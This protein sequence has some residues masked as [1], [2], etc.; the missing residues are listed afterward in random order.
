MITTKTSKL[1]MKALDERI[2]SLE[3]RVAALETSQAKPEKQ[4]SAKAK[5]S[6]KTSKPAK[7]T[8]AKSKSNDFDRKLYIKTAKQLGVKL[9]KSKSGTLK[10]A[11][12]EDRIKVYE[13]MGLE[14][15]E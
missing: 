6:A 11:R 10:V 5:K 8:S 7:K 3:K 1:T 9:T 13:A 4:V 15:E 2:N 12:K 14:I